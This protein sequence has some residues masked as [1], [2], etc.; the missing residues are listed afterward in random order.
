MVKG[1]VCDLKCHLKIV[2]FLFEGCYL[3]EFGLGGLFEGFEFRR[4]DFY[5]VIEGRSREIR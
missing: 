2:Y 1:N 3:G 4:R 5:Y